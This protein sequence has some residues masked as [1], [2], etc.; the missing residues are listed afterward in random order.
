MPLLP[1]DKAKLAALKLMPPKPAPSKPTAPAVAP[2]QAPARQSAPPAQ[3]MV[4][5]LSGGPKAEKYPV[6]YTGKMPDLDSDSC[7]TKELWL[8]LIPAGT[9]MMGNPDDELGRDGNETLHRVTLTQPF[10][11]GVFEVTQKQYE[12]ITDSNPSGYKG[13]MRPVTKI[14]YNMLR[15]RSE[16]WPE[17]NDVDASSFFGKLRSK[18]KMLVDLPTEAQW[19]YACRAG[20]TTA[21]NNGKNLRN[22]EQCSNLEKVGRYKNNQEDGKGGYSETT[23]VGMYL[24]NAWGLYDM[25]GN[26]SEL[27]LDWYKDDLGTSSVTD[28]KGAEPGEKRVERGGSSWFGA[29]RSRSAFRDG[30]R[31]DQMEWG[32]HSSFRVVVLPG[33]GQGDATTQPG[34]TMPAAAFDALYAE[35]FPQF[36]PALLKLHTIFTNETVK[37][38]LDRVRGHAAAL[39]DYAANL[40][41]LTPVFIQKADLEGVKAVEAARELTFRGEV[42]TSGACP[43]IAA[44][45]A[46]YAKRCAAADAK[47]ADALAALT[48]KYINVLTASLRELLQKKD[49]QTAELYKLEIDAADRARYATQTGKRE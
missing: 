2:A 10:Y 29:H 45:V 31:L 34:N 3:Y 11:I 44:L 6:T 36:P 49:L 8:R 12:L 30:I 46:A 25:H 43:E 5:D 23:K 41:K 32:Q 22:R 16:Q 24:P 42:D 39:G 21:L 35:K 27:C 37:I 38:D 33:P 28:P 40:N 1:L 47:A 17:N 4:I 48:V 13:D 7:R 19:E 26:A 9:F 20:T 18:T 14:L 15:G